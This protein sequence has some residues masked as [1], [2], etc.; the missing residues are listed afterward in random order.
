MLSTATL[1]EITE[2]EFCSRCLKKGIIPLRPLVDIGYDFVIEI[3]GSYHRVQVKRGRVRTVGNYS[4]VAVGN[5]G[6]YKDKSVFD[7]MAIHVPDLDQMWLIPAAEITATSGISQSFH[8]LHEWEP[9][10]F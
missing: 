5:L 8:R 3:E 1:G 7:D 2:L 10:V 9:Y 4:S 6:K